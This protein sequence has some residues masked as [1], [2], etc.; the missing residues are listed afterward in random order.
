MLT[1][2]VAARRTDSFHPGWRADP[3]LVDRALTPVWEIEG[4]LHDFS[5]ESRGQHRP[6]PPHGDGS[7]HRAAVEI[8]HTC[9][10]FC[11]TK[12]TSASPNA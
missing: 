7:G 12:T 4:K 5:A 10:R 2:E 11:R 9:H 8:T 6:L 1:A 3:D